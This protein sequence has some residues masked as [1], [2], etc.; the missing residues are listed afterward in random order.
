M[1]RNENLEILIG[2]IVLIFLS[3]LSIFLIVKK[4]KQ[5]QTDEYDTVV[6]EEAEEEILQLHFEQ[7]NQN[8]DIKENNTIN[9]NV[10]ESDDTQRQ[11]ENL[12]A[13]LTKNDYE[14]TQDSKYTEFYQPATMKKYE[15]KEYWQL[16][17]LFFYWNDYQLDAVDDLIHLPRVR[18][19]TNELADSNYFYY[20]GDLDTKGRPDGQGLAVYSDNS[21]YCGEWS[22][23]KRSGKG[24]WLQIFPDDIGTVKSINAVTEHSYNGE[25]LNDLPN[26]DGQEHISYDFELLKSSKEPLITNVIGEF[27][28]GFYHGD[29]Y[30]MT[31]NEA[32]KQIDWEA[33]AKKGQF[34]YCKEEKNVLNKRAVWEKMS[35]EENDPD[36]FHWIYTKNNV[37]HGIDGLKK[38]Q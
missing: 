21:Y 8:D 9:Q 11:D 5:D 28:E 38:M 33:K 17:E 31:A 20:Y 32:E 16:E 10:N 27:K 15:G 30:I 13:E 24:M 25:W 7:E 1:K 34:I 23:G 29:L 36:P 3:V 18:T 26:G 2:L 6:A 37:N 35:S 14:Q 4:E 12:P 19:F 22:E